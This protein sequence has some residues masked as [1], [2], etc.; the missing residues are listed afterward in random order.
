MINGEWNSRRRGVMWF[1]LTM[2]YQKRKSREIRPSRVGRVTC[3]MNADV[4]R[5]G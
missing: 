2:S 5:L 3:R 4:C 1:C